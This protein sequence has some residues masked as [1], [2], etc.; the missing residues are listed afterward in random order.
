M[1]GHFERFIA[2]SASPGLIV[3]SQTL[4]VASAAN[5]LHRISEPEA[6]DCV[7]SIYMVCLPGLE[8]RHVVTNEAVRI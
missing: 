6:E 7:K 5:W 1:P 8:A 3:N 4:S 2:N